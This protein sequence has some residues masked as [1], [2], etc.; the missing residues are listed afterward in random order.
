MAFFHSEVSWTRLRWLNE[1]LLRINISDHTFATL[2]DGSEM[3]DLGY[4]ED[5]Y[6]S[7][8][9]LG[10]VVIDLRGTDFKIANAVDC[11]STCDADCFQQCSQWT[12]TGWD[13]AIEVTCTHQGQ[14]CVVNCGGIR[15]YCFL[16]SDYLQLERPTSSPI[17]APTTGPISA[18]TTGPISAPTTSPIPAPT[19]PPPI[20]ASSPATYPASSPTSL[21]PTG[22]GE[23]SNCPNSVGWNLIVNQIDVANNLFPSGTKDTFLYNEDDESANPFMSL[24]NL[25]WECYRSVDGLFTFK[26]QWFDGDLDG[27]MNSTWRQSSIPSETTSITDF[28]YLEGDADTSNGC[29]GFHGVAIS[30]ED[31]CVIDGNGGAYCWYNCMGGISTHKDGLPSAN[32][33]IATGVQ[34][35]IYLHAPTTGPISAPTTSP[36]PAPTTSSIPAPTSPPVSASSPVAYDPLL[37]TLKP[38]AVPDYTLKGTLSYSS[39]YYAGSAFGTRPLYMS[40]W[41]ELSASSPGGNYCD[42]T[43]EGELSALS[44]QNLCS[45]NYYYFMFYYVLSFEVTEAYV[46][47]WSF[48]FMLDGTMFG[49]LGNSV[50]TASYDNEGTVTADLKAGV[51]NFTIVGSEECCDGAGW[52][53]VRRS[54]EQDYWPVVV[55]DYTAQASDPTAPPVSSP[56]PPPFPAALPVSDPTAPPV[57]LPTPPPFPAALPVSDP[58]ASPVSSPTFAQSCVSD[59]DC[60]RP[61][62]PVCECLSFRRNLLF[63][64]IICGDGR[65]VAAE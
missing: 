60:T 28:E 41:E 23:S 36:I 61:E 59:E 16:T 43:Y 30:D 32:D 1:E 44:N 5:C 35:Y 3:L 48:Q 33:N 18:P 45:G 64:A 13:P 7:Y 2:V 65:C 55:E 34:L 52:I 9:K 31:A 50:A 54:G 22:P 27:D 46:G 8:S 49:K 19:S 63:A 42:I 51:H 58:T 20:P 57:S 11:S 40:K 37:P 21:T 62:Q 56:T 24:G 6:G 12:S 47:T 10:E 17:S 53:K 14:R 26:V 4:A 25:N 29:T 38:T 39:R 15:G